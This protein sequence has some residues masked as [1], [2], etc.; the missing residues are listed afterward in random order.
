MMLST[1]ALF[2]W[3]LYF[4]G[5]YTAILYVLLIELTWKFA[6][7][8]ATPCQAIHCRFYPFGMYTL[9]S[10]QTEIWFSMTGRDK[11]SNP[12]CNLDNHQH[13]IYIS[14]LLVRFII[15]PSIIDNDN[16]NILTNNAFQGKVCDVTAL[17]GLDW[18]QTKPWNS[19]NI[20]YS[21]SSGHEIAVN[22]TGLFNS[23]MSKV[24]LGRKCRQE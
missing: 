1:Q 18:V 14:N 24:L 8:E 2:H 20:N 7:Y 22:K 15:L 13:V 3:L 16:T 10:I 19:M 12:W 4:F 5:F 21:A 23:W 9:A 17:K 6:I 11:V